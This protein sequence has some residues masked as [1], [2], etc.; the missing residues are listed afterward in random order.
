[1]AW[2]LDPANFVEAFFEAEGERVRLDPWQAKYLRSGAKLT[3][4]L[5]SRRVGGSWIMTAKMFMRSQVMAPYSGV[6]VSMNREEARGKIDYADEMFEAL[7]PRWRL[8]RI[9]RSRDEISFEDSRGRRSVLRS[10]AAK[11]PRG[12][13]GD[14]GISEL[15]HCMRQ[16]DIYE[17]ALHVTARSVGH[18]L[19]IESTPYGRRG[20]FYDIHRGRYP[21]FERLEVPWW[22][23][24]SL[25]SDIAKAAAEAPVM[26]TAER[27]EKFGSGALRAIFASMPLKVFK[28]ESELEF[29]ETEDAA[30]PFELLMKAAEADFGHTGDAALMFRSFEGPPSDA[31]WEWLSRAARG[32]LYAGFD[33]GRKRDKAALVIVEKTGEK[34]FTRMTISLRDAPFTTQKN[35]LD[36]AMRKGVRAMKIDSTGIGMD[37]AERMEAGWPGAAKGFTFTA[38][39]KAVLVAGLYGA[40]SDGRIVIPADRGL[41]AELGSIREAVSESGAALYTAPRGPHHADTAWALMLA[42]DAAKG[43]AV[44]VEIG[45]ERVAARRELKGF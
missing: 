40:L 6:F 44:E 31:G 1:M 30:F 41:L 23:S 22:L 34:F 35:T 36:T 29:S 12:R 24:A 28:R 17:G 4:I 32:D 42:L 43:N 27:V 39:S 13:G 10:L 19:S 26:S 5:K 8:K 15:P 33:P 11:A 14:V 20:V 21:A 7:P 3:S 16:E 9:A 2:L 38:R 25:C 18:Q 37:L 45:Y